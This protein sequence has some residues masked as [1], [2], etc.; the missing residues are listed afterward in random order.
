MFELL[1]PYPWMILLMYGIN[2]A[3]TALSLVCMW[4]IFTKMGLPGWKGIVP[5]YNIWTAL[6]KLKK[7]QYWFWIIL[8]SSLLLIV[9]LV[10][11][12]ASMILAMQYGAGDWFSG[13]I[14]GGGVLLMLVLLVCLFFLVRL[15]HAFSKSFGH[16]AGFTV[17]LVLLP[18]VFSP[19]MAFGPNEFTEPEEKKTKSETPPDEQA[20]VPEETHNEAEEVPVQEMEHQSDESPETEAVEE[21][22]ES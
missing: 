12:T 18:Y 19:I 5:Y 17:G 14:A 10:F 1:F 3:L 22:Q 15:T 9:G 16:G 7:P 8:A 2:T 6:K 20:E 4:F 13:I 21:Q 11:L